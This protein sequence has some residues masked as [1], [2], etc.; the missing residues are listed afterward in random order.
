MLMSVKAFNSKVAARTRAAVQIMEKT[1]DLLSKY[2]KTGG[3][4]RD[5]E[6]VAKAGTEAEAVEKQENA[7]KACVRML[8]ALGNRD[9]RVRRLLAEAAG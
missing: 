3:L 7:W 4:R 9:E 1:P 6:A 5:L 8:R 2:E